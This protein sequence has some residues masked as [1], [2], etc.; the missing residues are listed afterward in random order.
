MAHT[1]TR[2]PRLY[3][4]PANYRI[5]ALGRIDLTWKDSLEG[6]AVNI[7]TSQAGDPCTILE[8]E[9][10]DQAALAGVLKTLYELHLTVLTV[11]RMGE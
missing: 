2:Q 8:G 11:Q 3:D 6:M 9:L 7:A 5:C 1:T 4:R 10:S